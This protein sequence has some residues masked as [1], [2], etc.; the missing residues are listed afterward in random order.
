MMAK[1]EVKTAQFAAGVT[2]RLITQASRTFGH[3][4]TTQQPLQ[5][6]QPCRNIHPCKATHRPC[7]LIRRFRTQP[8]IHHQPDNRAPPPPRQQR[9]RQTVRPPGYRDCNRHRIRP[10]GQPWS[11]RLHA[12]RES[13]IANHPAALRT[14]HARGVIHPAPP[15]RNA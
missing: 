5:T 13:G 10:I 7:G 6:Q 8:V 9:K 14:H 12:S 15:P 2:Q 1:Q 11:Q 3:A 4:W